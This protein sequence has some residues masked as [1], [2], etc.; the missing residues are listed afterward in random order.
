MKKIIA[1]SILKKKIPAISEELE[2]IKRL[3]PEFDNEKI[4]QALNQKFDK[5]LEKLET[6]ITERQIRGLWASSGYKKISID[7]IKDISRLEPETVA[8]IFRKSLPVTS[9]KNPVYVKANPDNPRVLFINAPLI[10]LVEENDFLKRALILAQKRKCDVVIIPGNL[11]WLDLKRYSSKKPKRAEFFAEKETKNLVFRSFKEKFDILVRKL[12]QQFLN[13]DEKPYF[14]G[15]VLISLGKTE[16]ELVE[17]YTNEIVRRL[18]MTR[19]GELR[20]KLVSLRKSLK[21]ID[22]KYDEYIEQVKKEIQGVIREL[23]FIRMSNINEGYI[24]MI[25]RQ[26]EKYIIYVYEESLKAKV[27]SC[28]Q[29]FLDVGGLTFQVIQNYT[30]SAQDRALGQLIN[31]FRAKAKHRDLSH[32]LCIAGRTNRTYSSAPISYRSREKDVA[33]SH[34]EQLPCCLDNRAIREKRKELVRVG[35]SFLDA[36]SNSALTPGVVLYQGIREKKSKELICKKEAYFSPFFL[37]DELFEGSKWKLSRM[38][39]LEVEGDKHIGSSSVT[40]YLIPDFPIIRYH[41]Q[42]VHDF[43]IQLKAPIVGH[44]DLGDIIQGHKYPFESQP[45]KEVF[46]PSKLIQ[47]FGLKD[48]FRSL[49][50]QILRRGIFP[51]QAQ[52]SEY[53]EA[54]LSNYEDYFLDIIKRAR[55]AGIQFKGDLAPI[56]ILGGNHFI[57]TVEGEMNDGKLAADLLKNKLRHRIFKGNIDE[58]VKSPDFGGEPIGS[59]FIRFPEGGEFAISVRHK[60]I[61]GASKYDDPIRKA[62]DAHRK[63]GIFESWQQGRFSLNLSGHTHRGGFSHNPSESFD[64]CGSQTFHNAFGDKLGFPLNYIASHVQGIPKK[65]I[66]WGPIIRIPLEYSFFKKTSKY[67]KKWEINRKVLFEFSL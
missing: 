15:K 37:N 66:A 50:V 18:V 43:L 64:V 60:A 32:I 21:V 8:R 23:S 34:L 29:V 62:R 51:C 53:E 59:G 38:A 44:V 1:W 16:L 11:V 5:A 57:G 35:D 40:H 33:D 6:Q 48:S 63:R 19:G 46:G 24:K 20:M 61:A 39:Y 27:I 47:D 10:G 22:D 7:F 45:P 49:I 12:H 4:A 52:L 55:K 42:M 30:D 28:G 17:Q 56:M 26:M 14:K 36:I 58:F 31:E 67:W 65:G 25:S 9:Y 54:A 3:H 41:F 13:N 2:R